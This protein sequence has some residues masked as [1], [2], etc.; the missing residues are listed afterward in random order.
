MCPEETITSE[1]WRRCFSN[2]T[3][4][5]SG[6]EDVRFGHGP[7][8][9]VG[10][11]STGCQSS[12]HCFVS[13]H[14]GGRRCFLIVANVHVLDEFSVLLVLDSDGEATFVKYFGDQSVLEKIIEN[15][16]DLFALIGEVRRQ[17]TLFDIFQNPFEIRSTLASFDFFNGLEHGTKT[18]IR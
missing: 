16:D 4:H 18:R 10:S 3:I 5:F 8:L 15:D 9:F 12:G 17:R 11:D 2:V 1:F 7:R 13:I 14:R 6:I